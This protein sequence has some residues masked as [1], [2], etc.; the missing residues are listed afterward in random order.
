MT[1]RRVGA[2]VITDAV[3]YTT[4]D[5]VAAELSFFTPSPSV[6]MLLT[7]WART[8]LALSLPADPAWGTD[9]TTPAG[10]LFDAVRRAV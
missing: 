10:S 6:R 9:V 8:S 4:D 5:M 3:G 2:G 7:R 1:T